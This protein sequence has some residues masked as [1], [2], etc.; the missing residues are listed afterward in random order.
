VSVETAHDVSIGGEADESAVAL[1]DLDQLAAQLH[2]TASA[3]REDGIVRTV[4]VLGVRLAVGR[5]GDPNAPTTFTGP[6]ETGDPIHRLQA[7]IRSKADQTAGGPLA[8]IRLDE[9]GGLF[10]LTRWAQQPLNQQLHELHAALSGM[11]HEFPHVRGL[12]LSDGTDPWG[13]QTIELTS[14]RARGRPFAGPLALVRQLPQGR[15]RRTFVLPNEV[16][17]IEL[18]SDLEL[19]PA[20]WYAE[21]G[22]WLE[23][24]LHQLGWPSLNSLFA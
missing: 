4:Q 16:R 2:R 9:L 24:A 11:L 8:W 17:R 12:V 22:T 7:R 13:A 20:R 1:S 10:Q 14:S 6:P 3:V 23:W 5:R 15:S 21:E 19:S 18:P